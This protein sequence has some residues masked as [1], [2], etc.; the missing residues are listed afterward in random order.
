MIYNIKLQRVRLKMMMGESRGGILQE[1]SKRIL[2]TDRQLASQSNVSFI[3]LK[4]GE[5]DR[6]HA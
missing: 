5:K 1:G 2:S 3:E 4:K 6:I